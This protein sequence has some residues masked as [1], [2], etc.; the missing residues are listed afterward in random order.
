[1]AKESFLEEKDTIYLVPNAHFD[2]L[3][4]FT[5]EEHLYI[6]LMLV[7]KEVA[8]LV[9]TADFKF[10]IEQ[11]YLLEEMGSVHVKK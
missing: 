6:N 10:L 7:L 9:E 8:E 1:M 5:K 4:V 3:W 11:T 2:A